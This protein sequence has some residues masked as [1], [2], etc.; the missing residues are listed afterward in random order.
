[1][2][3]APENLKNESW[4]IA[5]QTKILFLVMLLLLFSQPVLAQFSVNQSRAIFSGQVV[6]SKT[7]NPIPE[8]TVYVRSEYGDVKT[9]TDAAGN[10]I[11]EVDNREDLKK[12]L[13]IFSH[14]D[15]KEKDINAVFA[16]YFRDKLTLS[17]KENK[18]VVKYKKNTLNLS[19]N[20]SG[21]ITTKQGRQIDFGVNCQ[22]N[23]FLTGF[24]LSTGNQ[25]YIGSLTD[26]KSELKIEV[27]EKTVKVE[28]T[29]PIKIE[30]RAA[31]F[32]R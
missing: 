20:E 29:T 5:M 30:A 18:T 11:L 6:D 25:L 27:D 2:M 14:P 26:S 9:K 16:D 3:H 13:I 32:K 8:V 31:M 24:K 23:D 15:Y 17:V 1:M 22:E 10:Y 28:A 19:C 12:F 4:A 7:G 21:T